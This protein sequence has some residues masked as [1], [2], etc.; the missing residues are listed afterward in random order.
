MS[1]HSFTPC[2]TFAGT[3]VD[4]WS[5]PEGWDFGRDHSSKWMRD[6]HE[7]DISLRFFPDLYFSASLGFFGWP[8]FIGHQLTKNQ[9][10][11]TTACSFLPE[12]HWTV[13]CEAIDDVVGCHGN[14]LS[15]P[16]LVLERWSITVLR[17][18]EVIAIVTGRREVIG[19][20]RQNLL[21]EIRLA[22]N[23]GLFG[24]VW[25]VNKHKC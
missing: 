3:Q 11:Q 8:T 6:S 17:W 20:W 13:Y 5:R 19:F 2:V 7:P 23:L 24:W 4:F 18:Q 22:F 12:K 14:V 10:I 15:Q 9:N 16:P 1:I 25:E 21:Q